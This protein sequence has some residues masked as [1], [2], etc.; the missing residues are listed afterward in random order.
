MNNYRI[1]CDKTKE[2]R[3]DI[4]VKSCCILVLAIELVKNFLKRGMEQAN[5]IEYRFGA[6]ERKK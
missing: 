5:I 3:D 4:D 2:I 6:N 1:L